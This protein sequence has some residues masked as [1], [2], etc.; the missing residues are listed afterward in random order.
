[1]NFYE[2]RRDQRLYN[3]GHQ[4]AYTAGYVCFI[5]SDGNNQ[6]DGNWERKYLDVDQIDYSAANKLIAEDFLL[7]SNDLEH[8]SHSV[9]YILSNILNTYFSQTLNKQ[10]VRH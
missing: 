3:K 6:L 7:D 10:K 2:Y 5:H 1:M 4:V 9:H 8:H